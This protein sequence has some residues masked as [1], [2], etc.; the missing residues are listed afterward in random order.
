[1][2][3]LDLTHPFANFLHAFG[4]ARKLLERAQERG[5]LI[6]GI[7]VYVSLI[8]GLPRMSLVLDKQLAGNFTGD[9]DD[10]I[11]QVTGGPKFT[12]K[13]IY[14]E[15]HQRNLID[16]D[17]RD[18]IIDL[19][20][21]RNAV[22]H[23][24]FLEGMTYTALEPLLDRYE[25][26]Y[27]RCYDVVNALEERQIARGGPGMTQVRK[28]NGSEAGDDVRRHVTMKLGFDPGFSEA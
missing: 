8:D 4:A 26:A 25:V 16:D 15:A 9:I 2:N 5:S 22:I 17:L 12:E 6:E 23:R 10:Y 7:V 19:Y 1:M 27:H 3:D 28:G 21:K 14:T 20:N 11:Q 18:E 13:M 24:F